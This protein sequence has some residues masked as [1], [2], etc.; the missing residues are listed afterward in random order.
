MST[1]ALANSSKR[2]AI[3]QL[4]IAAALILIPLM[5]GASFGVIFFLIPALLFAYVASVNYRYIKIFQ[6]YTSYFNENN[7]GIFHHYFNN[8]TYVWEMFINTNDETVRL[9]SNGRQKVFTFDQI[10]GCHYEVNS[11]TGTIGLDSTSIASGSFR[12]T[13]FFVVTTDLKDPVWHI[14]LISEKSKVN[15]KSPVFYADIQRQCESWL[16]VFEQ[17]VAKLR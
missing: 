16:N 12:D 13:G 3:I 8:G 15:M 17:V 14:R 11:Y 9:Q 5:L 2:K 10:K 7:D 6:T 4:V 1:L